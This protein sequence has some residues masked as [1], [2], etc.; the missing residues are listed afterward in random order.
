MADLDNVLRSL[1]SEIGR[2]TEIKR[3]LQCC[4]K[5]YFAILQINP[6]VGLDDLAQQLKKL[7]RRKSL[8]IHPDK[9]KNEDAPAAFSLLKR[10]EQILSLD[11]SEDF[12]DDDL[13]AKAAEKRALIG[14]YKEIDERLQLPIQADFGHADNENIREKVRL[15]LESHEKSQ[16]IEK[17]FAQRQE[18]QRREAL[19]AAAKEREL[20]K[21]WE[22]RWEQDRGDRVKLWR[23]FN[24]K[25]DKPK[26]KK[27]KVLA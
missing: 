4:P 26:K 12:T 7:Y 9:T 22:T 18:E 20:K 23:N 17:S 13:K 15:V 27:K 19:K 10:A 16:E 6:L 1:E 2:D 21:S 24:A 3:I 5:D 25:V 14:V 8:L 11:E